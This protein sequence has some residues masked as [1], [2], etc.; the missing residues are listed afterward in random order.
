MTK[1]ISRCRSARSAILLLSFATGVAAAADANDGALEEIVVTAQKRAQNLQDVGISVTAIGAEQLHDL[2]VVDTRDI[3]K[4][5]AGVI[6]DP[7]QSGDFERILMIRG[8]SQTDFSAHQESP[9][10]VYLDGIYASAP[11]E[12]AFQPY[13]LDRIEVLRGPQGTLYGRN[14]TGGLLNIISATPTAT[15]Q[16][17]AEAGGGSF[18]QKYVEAAVSGPLSDRVRVRLSGREDEDNGWWKNY[19]GG[20][21]FY[22]QRFRGARAQIEMDV[23]DHLLARFSLSYDGHGREREGAYSMESY[24]FVNGQPTPLPS[25]VDAWGTGPG[26][27]LIGYRNPYPQGPGSAFN[28]N[29]SLESRRLSPTLMLEWKLGSTTITSL[30]NFTD[31][32]MPYSEDCDGTPINAC[33]I[34][35]NQQFRRWSQ[36]LR[37]TGQEGAFTWTAGLYY[38]NISVAE[39]FH[40]DYPLYAGTD[41]AYDFFSNLTQ[42]TSSYAPFG[43]IEWKFTDKLRLTVGARYTEDRKGFDSKAY[44][45]ELGTAYG[46]AG[47][48]VEP[49]LAYDFSAATMGNLAT[50]KEGLP[51]GKLQLD[52]I[53]GANSLLYAS[54]SRGVKSAGYNANTTGFLTVAETPFK[55]EFVNAYDLGEKVELFDHHLRLNSSVFYYDYHRFQG[56]AYTGIQSIVGNY[57][58]EFYGGEMEIAAT[59]PSS[60]R[61]NLGVSFVH[62]LLKDIPTQY[63]GIRDEQAPLAPKYT[64]NGSVAKSTTLGPGR[65]TVQWSFDYVDDRYFSVD[66]NSAA[67]VKGSIGHNFRISYSLPENGIEVAAHVDN[68]FNAVRQEG[69]FDFVAALGETIK[70]YAPP[71]WWGVSIRKKF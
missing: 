64:V 11:A 1:A 39:Q 51:S 15:F 52:Y 65:L 25:N 34:S 62:S 12:L 41:F 69:V 63:N 14:S 24:Y 53:P 21:N 22:N 56:F 33:S 35:F 44:F 27:N 6:F 20:Q 70:T 32:S 37:A 55:S 47:V 28:P 8:I 30:S 29:G 23:T 57:D 36:E 46:G 17:Y 38:L 2:N 45:N 18:D 4:I 66:N 16:G 7:E 26:N 71:R 61:A 10:S 31:F 40:F 58:G 43:Q 60:I 49:V 9:N 54:V 5:A 59:L 48:T 19:T 50:Q 13:D 3:G 67:F 68:A 42:H